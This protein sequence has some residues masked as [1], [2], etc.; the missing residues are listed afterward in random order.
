MLQKIIELSQECLVRFWQLDPEFVI[1]HF[2]KNI[3]WI[4]SAKTQYTDTYEETVADFREIVKELK[5]CRLSH[6]EFTVAQNTGN[7]CTIAGRYV[8][9]TDDSVGY[10][11][12][13][14]QRCTFVWEI[15]Q[16]DPKIKH[17]HI[18]NPMGELKLAEGEKFVNALGEMS[19]KYWISRIRSLQ[20]K[21]KII[22]TDNKEITHFLT[23]SE[24]LY[25]NAIGRNCIIYTVDGA[26]IYS[27]SSITEFAEKAG[28]MFSFVH[29]S[30][31]VNNVYISAIHPYEITMYGGGKIPVP[32]KRYGEIKNNL[33]AFYQK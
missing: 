18:S 29:R 33:I 25:V 22:V 28:E 21:E 3:V 4:G 17:C 1:R 24:I 12:Q 16:N 14:Q 13:A 11:L 8:T 32:K 30:Y 10:F 9:T 19:K 2:D 26:E 27:R 23:A 5:P 7:I 31:V 6:Q 15:K 20:S